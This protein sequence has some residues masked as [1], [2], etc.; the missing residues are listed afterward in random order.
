MIL[1]K[2]RQWL[3]VF[4]GCG[5]LLTGLQAR[6]V[7]TPPTPKFRVKPQYPFELRK[8]GVVGRAVIE[9]IVDTQG[10]VRNARVVSCTHDEFGEAALAAVSK[11]KFKPGI[12][13]G[14][15]VNTRLQAPLEFTL[16][17]ES[18]AGPRPSPHPLQGITAGSSVAPQPPS[19]DSG[20]VYPFEDLMENKQG[21]LEATILISVEGMVV[22]T[23]W[24][25][26]PDA[27]FKLAIEAMLDSVR[28]PAAVE[29]GKA[30][31]KTLDLKWV[32]NPLD[33]EVRISDSGAAILKR[34]RLGGDAAHF[35][36]GK[37]LDR[38]LRAYER[39]APVFPT[40]LPLTVETGEAMIEFF[41]D[42]TGRLQ[43]PRIVSATDPSFGYAACQ[44]IVRWRF[45]RPTVQGQPTVT[46]VQ[47]PVH[48]K[49]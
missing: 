8:A 3:I 40:R 43:L 46:R 4:L 17:D 48:F 37:D 23:T 27:D 44:A 18:P 2:A 26:E 38:A 10:D 47:Q 42:E 7:D 5:L 15:A 16:N 36:G 19:V 33:G 35:T 11:W 12:K 45:N 22:D 28:F 13:D 1:G 14:R 30:V 31:A 29:D 34:L 20:A 9:F 39:R 6:M 32:F 24:Q 21:T 41:V 49:R 25:G